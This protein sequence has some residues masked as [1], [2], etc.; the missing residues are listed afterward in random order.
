MDSAEVRRKRAEAAAALNG[1][2]ANG[3][4]VTECAYSALLANLDGA[5]YTTPPGRLAERVDR[6]AALVAT[7]LQDVAMLTGS[8]TVNST[9]DDVEGADATV[10]QGNEDEALAV[11]AATARL[12]AL[13]ERLK[14]AAGEAAAATAAWPERTP[15]ATSTATMAGAAGDSGKVGKRGDNSSAESHGLSSQ[16][17]V[18]RGLASLEHRLGRLEAFVGSAAGAAGHGA[19]LRADGSCGSG[20]AARIERLGQLIHALTPDALAQVSSECRTATDAIEALASSHT[21]QLDDDESKLL[22]PG[23]LLSDVQAAVCQCS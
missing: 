11:S 2:A 18:E 17:G 21:P 19:G 13:G 23:V 1:D 9:E 14:L 10:A 6:V 15:A 7:T 5:I 16:E 4:A 8:S 20:L 3:A 12:A 22:P